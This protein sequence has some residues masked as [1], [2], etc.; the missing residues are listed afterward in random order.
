MTSQ[1]EEVVTI[2]SVIFR[3]D[4]KPLI[5]VYLLRMFSFQHIPSWSLTPFNA[6]IINKMAAEWNHFDVMISTQHWLLMSRMLYLVEQP[7]HLEP[8]YNNIICIVA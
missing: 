7:I 1:N 4:M 6:L 8:V 2:I 3:Q 5:T